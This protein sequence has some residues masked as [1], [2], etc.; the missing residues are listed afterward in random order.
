LR[1]KL[2]GAAA[3][4]EDRAGC[5]DITLPAIAA[6]DPSY[7]AHGSYD[8]SQTCSHQAIAILSRARALFSA[9]ERSLRS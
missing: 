9:S 1:L 3:A 5:F 8:L 2:H 7:H 6:G 4:F